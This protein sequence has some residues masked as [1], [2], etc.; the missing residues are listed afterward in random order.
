MKRA[1]VDRIRKFRSFPF[2]SYEAAVNR[3]D[4]L[5]EYNVWV[6][7]VL[8]M[9]LTGLGGNFLVSGNPIKKILFELGAMEWETSLMRNF[10]F[11]NALAVGIGTNLLMYV[12]SIYITEFVGPAWTSFSGFFILF[13]SWYRIWTYSEYSATFVSVAAAAIGS[14]LVFHSLQTT[15]N[16]VAKER[17]D[18]LIL[19]WFTFAESFS[20]V[21]PILVQYWV[22]FAKS[23]EYSF[24]S[25]WVW[26]FSVSAVVS[27]LFLPSSLPIRSERDLSYDDIQEDS[28][29]RFL[30]TAPHP[31][32]KSFLWDREIRTRMFVPPHSDPFRGDP[33]NA[34]DEEHSRK[35]IIPGD[36]PG[37]LLHSTTI[38]PRLFAQDGTKRPPD[39]PVFW[40]LNRFQMAVQPQFV[41]ICIGLGWLQFLVSWENFNLT[42]PF[43]SA[44]IDFWAIMK[45]SNAAQ[46]LHTSP[47]IT[48]TYS[49][50]I[51]VFVSLCYLCYYVLYRLAAPTLPIGLCLD[52]QCRIELV[53]FELD[54]VDGC[55][56]THVYSGMRSCPPTN[57]PMYFQALLSLLFSMVPYIFV[58]L[59]SFSCI[60][61]LYPLVKSFGIAIIAC[62]YHY[63]I[64]FPLFVAD[65]FGPRHFYFLFSLS[66]ASR[67][68]V[69][70]IPD[71]EHYANLRA[72]SSGRCGRIS[73]QFIFNRTSTIVYKYVQ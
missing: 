34:S 13:F 60:L 3:Y 36:I 1:A 52:H 61:L 12:P 21:I 48:N 35:L 33:I 5:L 38:D 8:S 54:T 47:T 31:G 70:W 68:A 73:L 27:S 55:F 72:A 18:I 32:W 65:M 19:A 41:F 11:N 64:I 28:L 30:S 51:V 62:E 29:I 59:I 53:V 43:F 4:T 56:L 37:T 66:L 40:K 15:A 14:S 22:E 63:S 6:K 46:E 16:M 71:C 25:S 10:A 2:Q 42:E 67:A 17:V 50:S 58:Q 20:V 23:Q 39:D 57:S 7:I 9:V 69:R 26:C 49:V 44:S 24:S 45:W